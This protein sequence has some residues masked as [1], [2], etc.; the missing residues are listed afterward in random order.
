MSFD[1]AILDKVI[2]GLLELKLKS[3]QHNEVFELYDFQKHGNH[4]FATGYS[5]S[6]RILNGRLVEIK[7]DLLLSLINVFF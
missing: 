4:L 6:R 7:Q 5:K 2:Y 1:E 3:L